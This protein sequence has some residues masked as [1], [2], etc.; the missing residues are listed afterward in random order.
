MHIVHS[1]SSRD[2]GRHE[3]RDTRRTA[4][5]TA[6]SNDDGSDN[7]L[8]NGRLTVVNSSTVIMVAQPGKTVQIESSHTGAGPKPG[9]R[10]G[11]TV[12]L[13]ATLDWKT[14]ASGV[15]SNLDLPTVHVTLP[16]R[17]CPKVRFS[18]E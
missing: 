16:N 8:D 2:G 6:G 17:G 7:L 12:K 11:E 13:K 10:R 5:V 3:F 15:Q 9:L 14:S 1:L 4:Y 18:S